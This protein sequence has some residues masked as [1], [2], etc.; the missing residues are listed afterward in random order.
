MI[1]IRHMEVEDHPNPL[2]GSVS[3]N[4]LESPLL[5]HPMGNP[6]TVTSK[7][8]DVIYVPITFMAITH[9]E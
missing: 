1:H 9:L 6:N 3:V 4:V 2:G 7:C 5:L 8:S